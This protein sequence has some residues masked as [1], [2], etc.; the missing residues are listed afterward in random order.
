M[1]PKIIGM[2]KKFTQF[3]W[4]AAVILFYKV[5]NETSQLLLYMES[6]LV[7]IYQLSSKVKETC[8]NQQEI[9]EE[10]DYEYLPSNVEITD[11]DL[12]NGLIVIT[13]TSNGAENNEEFQLTVVAESKVKVDTIRQDLLSVV[14]ENITE[15]FKKTLEDES[16]DAMKLLNVNEW[17]LTDV[18][19]CVERDLKFVQ[20]LYERFKSCLDVYEYNL[21]EAKR[22]WKRVRALTHFEPMFLFSTP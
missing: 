18:E 15:R 11:E 21:A 1:Y 2:R 22:E 9:L 17:G 5:L 3:G 7:L 10:E 12:E 6:D 4:F 13:P 14:Q 16:L 19:S 8:F 20:F